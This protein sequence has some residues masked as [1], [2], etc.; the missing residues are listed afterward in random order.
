[1]QDVYQIKKRVRDAIITNLKNF[2]KTHEKYR[3]V[4]TE[5]G[6]VDLERTKIMISDVT[7]NEV[8]KIPVIYVDVMSGTETRLIDHDLLYEEFTEEGLRVE[9]STYLS[10]TCTILVY[11]YDTIVRDELAD[12]VYQSIKRYLKDLNKNGVVVRK[13][14]MEAERRVMIQDRW[15]YT[16]G[17]RLDLGAEWIEDE[18][19]V[20]ENIERVGVEVERG[21]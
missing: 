10:L 21:S 4:E 6:I 9:R 7:P 3:Y 18:E 14:D 19:I 11:A 16:S 2:F 1:M 20:A 17:L 15:Y 12:L 13:V 5:E 8:L